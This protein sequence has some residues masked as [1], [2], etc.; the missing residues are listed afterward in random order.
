MEGP[1]PNIRAALGTTT[2]WSSAQEVGLIET[3]LG[4]SLEHLGPIQS[5]HRHLR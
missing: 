3:P 5:P 2:P 4:T 1:H